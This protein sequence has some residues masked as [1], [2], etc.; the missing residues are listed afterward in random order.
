MEILVNGTRNNSLKI[1]HLKI[2]NLILFHAE[3]HIHYTFC[4]NFCFIGQFHQQSVQMLNTQLWLF[5]T[6]SGS[7]G[8]Y[9]RINVLAFKMNNFAAVMYNKLKDSAKTSLEVNE[10]V[11]NCTLALFSEN[12]NNNNSPRNNVVFVFCFFIKI[13]H[14]LLQK[15]AWFELKLI[16]NPQTDV[17]RLQ[18]HWMNYTTSHRQHTATSSKQDTLHLWHGI[19]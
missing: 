14:F 5:R 16:Q 11:M 3:R 7:L 12:C 2:Y 1:T 6:M 18:C 4:V 9:S 8:V 13:Q 17:E 15:L 19:I 10:F